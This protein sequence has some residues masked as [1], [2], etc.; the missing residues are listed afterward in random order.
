MNPRVA[1]IINGAKSKGIAK[2]EEIN[3]VFKD[4]DYK[5]FKTTHK[6]HAIVLASDAVKQ[7]YQILISIGGDGTLNEVLNGI[8]YIASHD[9]SINLRAI[10]LGVLPMGSGNDFVRSLENSYNLEAL[11]ESLYEPI[12]MTIDIGVAEF[13][14]ESNNFTKRYFINVADIGIG[15]VIAEKLSRYNRWMGATLTYQRAI[16]STFFN[17]KPQPISATFGHVKT[18]MNI[19]SFVVANSRYF[20]SGLGIAPNASFR[21]GL[22]DLVILKEISIFDYI[23]HLSTLRKCQKI[24]HPEVSYSQ[25]R[26]VVLDAQIPLPIDM[27]GEFVGYTPV[28][29]YV[30]PQKL[31]FLIP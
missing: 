8:L 10:Y 28:K 26:E 30:L 7:G 20:G 27:D 3:A 16:F 6:S 5:V 4:F 22:L 21:D 25:S 15:G 1:F 23:Q 9:V 29:F 13:M 18:E 24:I 19:M 2:I 31:N 17:Y 12:Y 11:K 14:D